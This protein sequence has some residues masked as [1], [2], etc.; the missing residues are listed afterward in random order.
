MGF[1][2][3]LATY[4]GRLNQPEPSWFTKMANVEVQ[5]APKQ[6]YWILGR[7]YKA[8]TCFTHSAVDDPFKTA[9]GSHGA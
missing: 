9:S 6:M 5:F 2:H 4:F 1:E 8:S 3:G 7:V